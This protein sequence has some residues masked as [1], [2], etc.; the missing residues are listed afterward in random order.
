[1]SGDIGPTRRVEGRGPIELRPILLVGAPRFERGTPCAQGRETKTGN[2]PFW[3][4]PESLDY[5]ALWAAMGRWGREQ[6]QIRYSAGVRQFARAVRPDRGRP[7]ADECARLPRNAASRV[8]NGADTSRIEAR[9]R[10][11]LT[12]RPARS[13]DR[14]AIPFASLFPP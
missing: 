12:A 2:R 3:I 11:P 1:M 13:I 4:G 7:A 5:R 8:I 6:L 9:A 14:R 10:N